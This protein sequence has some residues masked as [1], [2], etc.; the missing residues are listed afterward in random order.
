MKK[1]KPGIGGKVILIGVPLLAAVFGTLFVMS[2]RPQVVRDIRRLSASD[3]EGVFLSMYDVSAYS[4]EDF[5]TYLGVPTVKTEYTVKKWDDLSRYLTHIFSSG[6]TVTHIFLCLDP[7]IL[8]KDSDR[9]E[10]RWTEDME[11][12]LTPCITAHSD[13][14]YEIMLPAPSLQYWVGLEPDRMSER[15]ESFRRLIDNLYAYENV[16]VFFMGGEKWLIAN[17]GNYLRNGVPNEQVS[18][19][20]F[21]HTFCDHNYA[22]TS[23]N[24]S[25]LFERLYAQVEQERETPAEYAD[26]SDRCL[27]FLGDSVMVY[28]PG[29]YSVPGVVEGLSHAQ[30]YNCGVG[31]TAASGDP[32]DGLNFCSMAKRFVAGDADGLD[33][34]SDFARGL[35]AYL[36]DDHNGKKYCFVVEYGLNDYFGGCPVENPQDPYDTGTYAGALRTGI[37]T[38]QEAY[39]DADILVLAPTYT[40]MF[41]G[42]TEVQSEAGG[43]LTD[44]VDAALRV[45]QE[46]GVYCANNYA[47]SGI[48]AENQEQYLADLVHPNET[49]AFLLGTEIIDYIDAIDSTGN[50]DA[51]L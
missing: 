36:R 4:E 38:L 47:D 46:M 14:Q 51:S 10:G 5:V 7:M 22:I 3:Y 31:G 28:Y 25:V 20:M 12:Y 45:A 11:T 30:V 32:A 26:L 29:S 33:E 44:Y 40:G 16:S 24:A 39:P 43:V 34:E 50:A 27:I 19:K 42:G 2:G 35:K 48:N 23:E 49:G 15:L 9:D 21:L 37:R 17:P 13:V 1:G 8:W 41:A 18:Q 6:N